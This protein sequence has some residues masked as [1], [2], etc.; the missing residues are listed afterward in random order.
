MADLPANLL[1]QAPQAPA[2]PPSVSQ[3][4]VP[5]RPSDSRIPYEQAIISVGGVDW[6]DWESVFVQLRWADSFAYFRFTTVER[7]AG[8]LS[9]GAIISPQFGPGA[10]CTI[11]LGGIPVVAGV[12]ETRQVAYDANRH[13]VELQGKSL[14][15]VVARS[16]VNTKS[17][18]FD[19]MTWL[20]VAQKVVS[21]YPTKIIPI[22][23]LNSI[24]FDKLSNQQGEHIW[25]FLERIARP[26]GIILGS[27]SFGNFLAIGDHSA[28]VLNTQLIE[29]QNIKKMQCV[30][31]K[32]E[33][34][35]QYNVTG[36]A[37]ASDDNAYT[38]ASEMEGRWAGTGILNSILIT[39]AEQPVKSVGE[40]TDRA[41]NEA[42]WH[43]GPVIEVTV[44]VQGWYRDD[45]NI[46][47]PGDN[48]FVYSP[49]C[50]LNM[51][52]KI[53]TATFTQDN[54]NGTETTLELK[55]PWALKDNA[56]LNPGP[57]STNTTMPAQNNPN[58]TSVEP[59]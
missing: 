5:K 45:E 32:D 12:I 13:G 6:K 27:D 9:Q 17:G 49:M 22:G 46:W 1:T 11:N 7:Q 34:Y 50:P 19:G 44:T 38:K 20:Q 58:G 42:L 18:S 23:V 25:D 3:Y 28:P 48:V 31:H 57:T 51:M 8:G 35:A 29:G 10:Q 59:H 33:V 53:Q 37:P 56:Q 16:S 4:E 41:K 36:Q 15:S 39:P 54:N 43:E 14:T 24:P 2:S 30:M 52:M 21:P 47:W 55:Q 40:L 26:R